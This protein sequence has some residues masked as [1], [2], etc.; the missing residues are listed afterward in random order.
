M[1]KRKAKQLEKENLQKNVDLFTQLY[2]DFRK[3]RAAFEEQKYSER[4]TELE[5]SLNM[6]WSLPQ[7]AQYRGK[8]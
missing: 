7:F 3:F 5:S 8:K 1:F 2:S 6:I 4:L